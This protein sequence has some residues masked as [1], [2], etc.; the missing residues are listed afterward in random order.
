MPKC[1]LSNRSEFS[2]VVGWVFGTTE[3]TENTEVKTQRVDRRVKNRVRSHFYDGI[4]GR[5]E[6]G[7][8]C[9]RFPMPSGR[10]AFTPKALYS[11]AQGRAAH[12]G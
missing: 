8:A 5:L 10:V 2:C 9:S 12:P 1:L 6:R 7:D 11:S 4:V 3:D